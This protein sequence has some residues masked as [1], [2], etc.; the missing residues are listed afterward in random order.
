MSNLW[1]DHPFICEQLVANCPTTVSN[2]HSRDIQKRL[3]GDMEVL[4]G[5]EVGRLRR[6]RD[7]IYESSSLGDD[8]VQVMHASS[9][10]HRGCFLN[11]PIRVTRVPLRGFGRHV[12]FGD[13]L[14]L[15]FDRSGPPDAKTTGHPL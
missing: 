3:L 14:V 4:V 13:I 15:K 8:I 5:R 10:I 7:K 1:R 6:C 2:L 9:R 12:E 11:G